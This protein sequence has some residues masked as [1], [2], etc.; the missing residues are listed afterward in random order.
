MRTNEKQDNR[1]LPQS[2]YARP[3]RIVARDLLGRRLVHSLEGERISGLI[4]ET[5]AYCDA[6]GPEVRDQACHASANQGRPTERTALMFGPPGYAYVY[7]TYGLHW[8]FNVVTGQEGEANAVLIRAL[9]P[10]EGEQQMAAHRGRPRPEWTN[11][12]AK[13]TQA[14]AIGKVHN[15]AK[16]FGPD[17]AIWIEAGSPVAAEAVAVGPRIGL[18]NTPEPWLSRPWRYWIEGSKFVSR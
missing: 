2:F 14:L 12:P 10:Q 11:G 16:L 3:A 13:L 9:E 17:T 6:D 15:G 7:F 1:Q 18:G 8:L 4:V 5:E